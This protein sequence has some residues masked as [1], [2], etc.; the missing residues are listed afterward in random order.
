[1]G[2]VDLS[3]T[4]TSALTWITSVPTEICIIFRN[5]TGSLM[6]LISQAPVHK[7]QVH[8]GRLGILCSSSPASLTSPSMTF[9]LSVF[10]CFLRKWCLSVSRD[11]DRK[12]KFIEQKV[13]LKPNSVSPLTIL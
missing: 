9:C 5:Q 3:V 7:D 10:V 12:A 6:S 13:K 8:N 2:K 1:M 11:E 4:V